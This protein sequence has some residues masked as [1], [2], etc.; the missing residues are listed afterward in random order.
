MGEYR[1]DGYI[2]R[3]SSKHGYDIFRRGGELMY[4]A[5]IIDLAYA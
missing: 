5:E 4:V 1:D 3:G 2:V